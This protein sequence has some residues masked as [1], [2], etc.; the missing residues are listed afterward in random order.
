LPDKP[1]I[2]H[3]ASEQA[4]VIMA[5]DPAAPGMSRVADQLE[6][7]AFL[8]G[9]RAFYYAIEAAKRTAANECGRPIIAVLAS[10]QPSLVAIAARDPAVER[11]AV[12]HSSKLP[13]SRLK[14]IAA[15]A[16]FSVVDLTLVNDDESERSAIVLGADPDRIARLGDPIT[17]R[18]LAEPQRRQ[19]TSATVEAAASLALDAAELTGLV[20]IAEKL[21]PD[22]GVN[23][24][25][26]HRVLPLDEIRTYGRPQM[27]LAAPIF[28]AQLEAIAT[29]MG[30]TGVN[31]I[32]EA[33]ATGRVAITF[34]DGYED[35]YRVALPIMRRHDTP[36]CVFIV[37]DL[38]GRPEAL[39][40][41]RVGRGLFAWWMADDR[42]ALPE[43]LPAG[44]SQ[45]ATAANLQAARGIIADVLGE[46]NEVT[47]EVRQRAVEAAE[48]VAAD[49]EDG[50]TMLSWSEVD[51]M[52][53]AGIS[54]GSHTKH[55]VCLDQVPAEVARD[56]LFGAQTELETK[57]DHAPEAVK[58]TALP[59]GKL[60]P[61]SEE[62]LRA[63]GFLGVM[64][65]EAGVNRPGDASLFVKR[66]D[67]KMLTLKGRH[68]PAKLRLE[69]TGLVDRL[70]GRW[71]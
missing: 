14:R 24:V 66:R 30:F 47:E 51:E 33:S 35:N 57:L 67:G 69:L 50:R 2:P 32:R 31:D 45:L 65:T 11:V 27:A 61:L 59:R 64:T 25:N 4:L 36:A 21:A 37:T 42:P 41:D 53:R 19:G 44:A 56:E 26:Y 5:V 8:P 15:R 54:F 10:N 22:K 6:A 3:S 28:D 71:S 7:A 23:V 63:A 49:V 62:E 16:F 13:L 70:R 60:G 39:W 55:H 68:H 48:A 18:L 40:W 17:E 52:R 46:L 9:R 20:A 1:I 58:L 29:K 43:G 34:D 12:Y 38:V